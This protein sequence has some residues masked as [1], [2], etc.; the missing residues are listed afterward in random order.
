MM[1]WNNWLKL[2]LEGHNKPKANPIQ[3][4]SVSLFFNSL[5]SKNWVWSRY[6]GFRVRLGPEH[7]RFFRTPARSEPGFRS[8]DSS[9]VRGVVREY[10]VVRDRP[11]ERLQQAAPE[12]VTGTR[13]LFS[14]R[15]SVTRHKYGL[16]NRAR[17]TDMA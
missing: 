3:S 15:G 2:G 16:R 11:G 13:R 8:G 14:R 6:T 5:T 9:G 10:S 17:S 12:A 7:G 1:Q 4:Q